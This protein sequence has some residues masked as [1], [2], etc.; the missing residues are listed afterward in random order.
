[1]TFHKQK[2]NCGKL[3]KEIEKMAKENKKVVAIGE[4][5]LQDYRG[6]E[7]KMRKLQK[8]AF[9]EQIKIANKL[10]LR[11]VIHTREAVMDTIQIL[12]ENYV[13]KT[14]GNISL[15]STK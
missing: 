10:N 2:K 1:M 8:R 3:F 9:I 7:E 13:R 5:G 11:I 12:K 4:I 14:Q 15:L 6:E